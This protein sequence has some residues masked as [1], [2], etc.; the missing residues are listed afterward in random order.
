[1][2]P[3]KSSFDNNIEV[4]L[5]NPETYNH[6]PNNIVELEDRMFKNIGYYYCYV[7]YFHKDV[8][9]RGWFVNQE[10]RISVL[11][12]YFTENRKGHNYDDNI[13]W[14][15]EQVYRFEDEIENMC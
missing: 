5:D 4:D 2:R 10:E 11:I 14:Y 8:K 15:Q 1:M 3:F 13:L 12:K 9:D 6:L 7:N